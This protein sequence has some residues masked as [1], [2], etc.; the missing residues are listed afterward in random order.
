MPFDFDG[1]ARVVAAGLGVSV[2]PREVVEPLAGSLALRIV[3]LADAWSTRQLYASR[4][5]LVV[6]NG[7][8]Q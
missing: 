5:A 3:P 4:A 8:K 6:A 1:V 7:L 2:L